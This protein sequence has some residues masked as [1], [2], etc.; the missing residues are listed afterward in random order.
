[1]PVNVMSS[2]YRAKGEEILTGKA[3]IKDDGY[4]LEIVIPVQ[5]G[6]VHMIAAVMMCIWLIGWI[7]GE[8][9]AIGILLDFGPLS[10]SDQTMQF[11]FGTFIGLW[12]IVWTLVG[13]TAFALTVWF[14]FGKNII[15]YSQGILFVSKRALIFK[16]EKHYSAFEIKNMRLRLFASA[17][18]STVQRCQRHS[19]Y[20]D[21]LAF[22]HGKKIVTFAAGIDEVE[23]K[24]I[25]N[26]FHKKGL[27]MDENFSE[28]M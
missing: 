12:L 23:A 8:I 14:L 27:H 10:G 18:Y 19:P 25:L 13:V 26:L 7:F 2:E 21:M 16:R 3:S 24:H 20:I 28:S 15:V 22:D 11:T 4:S 1:M 5:K 6:I 9:T 17:P